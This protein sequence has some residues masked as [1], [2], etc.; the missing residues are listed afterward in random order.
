MQILLAAPLA[1]LWLLAW[2]GIEPHLRREARARRLPDARVVFTPLLPADTHVRWKVRHRRLPVMGRCWA[3]T[4][5]R[6]K[7]RRSARACVDE[8]RGQIRAGHVR[9]T[10]EHNGMRAT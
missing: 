2:P 6:W 8:S 1:T 9:W 4:H 7:V 5:V 10:R 3:D